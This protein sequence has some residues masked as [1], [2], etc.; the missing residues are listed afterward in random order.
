MGRLPRGAERVEGHRVR[1]AAAL[2]SC[3]PRRLR[4]RDQPR[5]PRRARRRRRGA[6]ADGLI[7]ARNQPA[8]RVAGGGAVRQAD[9]AEPAQAIGRGGCWRG[10]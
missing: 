4:G 8:V 3:R 7:R 9:G 6:A 10:R 2:V 5:I 1:R